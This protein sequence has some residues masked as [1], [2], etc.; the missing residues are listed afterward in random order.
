MPG[1]GA[2]RHRGTLLGAAATTPTRE[3]HEQPEA[4]QACRQHQRPAGIGA[5]GHRQPASGR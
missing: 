4:Q 2:R 1:R 3:Q 5:A